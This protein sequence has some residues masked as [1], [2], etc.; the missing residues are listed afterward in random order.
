M[1]VPM[2]T[3]D[4]PCG[5]LWPQYLP[6]EILDVWQLEVLKVRDNPLVELPQDIDR[7]RNLRVLVASYC[8]LTALPPG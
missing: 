8:L 5:S 1:Y 6:V 4:R 2:D 3:C 7:L